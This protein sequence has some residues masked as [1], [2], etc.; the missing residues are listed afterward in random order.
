MFFGGAGV[1]TESGIP[2]FRSPDGLYARSS[3][4]PPE[5]MLSRRFFFSHT[6]EFFDFYR[7]AILC[8]LDCKP[9]PAHT[10]C[11]EWERAGLVDAVVTQNIDG[12]H[13]AAGSKKVYGATAVST[14]AGAMTLTACARATACRIASAAALSSRM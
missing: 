12:L 2:D 14:A 6:K 3:A 4:Y 10:L 9:N 5:E 8:C 13:T 7:S 1:S 11:A